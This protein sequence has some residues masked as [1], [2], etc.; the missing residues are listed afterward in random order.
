MLIQ[1][2]CQLQSLE[3]MLLLQTILE[4]DAQRLSFKQVFS[5]NT[6]FPKEFMDEII[7]RD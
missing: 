1:A 3:R 4:P 2:R 7:A 5:H 6:K